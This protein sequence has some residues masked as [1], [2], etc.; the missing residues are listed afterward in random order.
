MKQDSENPWKVSAIEDFQFFCCPE[1]DCRNHSKDDF[2]AHAF[3]T[4]PDAK[5]ALKDIFGIY[6]VIEVKAEKADDDISDIEQRPDLEGNNEPEELFEAIPEDDSFFSSENPEIKDTKDPFLSNFVASIETK[7]AVSEAK[8][9][10]SE[11]S[12]QSPGSSAFTCKNCKITFCSLTKLVDHKLSVHRSGGIKS[13]DVKK[14]QHK[15]VSCKYCKAKYGSDADLKKH[16]LA[17]HKSA[18]DQMEVDNSEGT[19]S[20]ELYCKECHICYNSRSKLNMHLQKVHGSDIY[21]CKVCKA[22]FG[23][24][25]NL[26]HHSLER[27]K[28]LIGGPDGDTFQCPTC[29]TQFNTSLQLRKHEDCHH[30]KAESYS[31]EFCGKVFTTK[32]SLISHSK[33]FHEK[34]TPIEEHECEFC[35][36]KFVS[37]KIVI[38]S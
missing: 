27:H 24:E 2:L 25:A 10:P 37:N 1:C 13:S 20:M 28:M 36:K 38:I 14:Q 17:R 8:S 9:F 12:T 35:G 21:P 5:E 15:I 3:E 16:M 6:T 32:H 22:K 18:F 29:N 7:S 31:C 4:H 23:S 11:S 34:G 19:S 26:K 30:K 33:R